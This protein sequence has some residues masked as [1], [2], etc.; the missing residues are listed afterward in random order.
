MGK[1]LSKAQEKLRDALID[2]NIAY[3]QK[4]ENFLNE[5]ED[6]HTVSIRS[7]N[8]LIDIYNTL[9]KA[10]GAMTH[11]AYANL[12]TIH[13]G[14]PI[15]SATDMFGNISEEF[16]F[17]SEEQEQ[18]ILSSLIPIDE[19]LD[20]YNHFKKN[21]KLLVDDIFAENSIIFRFEGMN[22][23]FLELKEICE[24]NWVFPP[25]SSKNSI[26]KN[27]QFIAPITVTTMPIQTPFHIEL[28]L[29][30]HHKLA[31]GQL[32]KSKLEKIRTIVKAIN[33]QL[34]FA[35]LVDQV[36]LIQNV[37][38]GL[39]QDTTIGE[40]TNI[41]SGNAIGDNAISKGE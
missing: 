24:G 2:N 35:M 15:G 33:A 39:S 8:E 7:I 25:K 14:P 5:I 23:L 31:S 26:L 13:L 6:F 29:K 4:V 34:P 17:L 36:P 37:V 21:I 10:H 38:T 1:E 18:T 22:N 9:D 20:I 28:Y 19:Y 11:G 40:H 41:G 27:K 16:D 32:L 30:Y 3:L 12:Y